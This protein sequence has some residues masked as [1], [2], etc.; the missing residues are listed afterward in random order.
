MRF[1]KYIIVLVFVLNMMILHSLF[2][3]SLHNGHF[4][5]IFYIW[6]PECCVLLDALEQ[7]TRNPA[8]TTVLARSL[9]HILQLSAEKTALSFKT[10]N[11]VPRMLKVACIH[12]QESKRSAIDFTDFSISSTASFQSHEL[13][14]S[15]AESESWEKCMKTFMDLF[16]VYFS[17]SDDAKISIL[18]SSP[19]I[20]CLF[21]LFWE[22]DLRNLM[23][24]YVLD[25]MK[26][27]HSIFHNLLSSLSV[28]G[29]MSFFRLAV[30]STYWRARE[31]KSVSLLQ[32]LG[33]IY[34][35]ER[36]RK[37]FF[38]F[39]DRVAHWNERDVV[40]R[41]SG[42]WNELFFCFVLFLFV[43]LWGFYFYFLYSHINIKI[44]VNWH[45]QLLSSVT[46][47]IKHCSVRVN[48]FCMLYLCWTEILMINN[49]N[50][51]NIT[52]KEI[53]NVFLKMK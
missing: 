25:L 4:Y 35:C 9:L 7:S 17:S 6:Q 42:N 5:L 50:L 49:F 43:C 31:S 39:S 22:E 3:S 21:D 41:S 28:L 38:Q 18:C 33:D 14:Y 44:F 24:M 26:V 36:T 29:L 12:V 52:N 27:C 45:A 19:C 51:K 32:V 53:N 40:N 15:P 23:L 34:T 2:G 30:S 16:A 47:I 20:S 11:A 8:L 1:K 48:V 37:K 46:S 10:L 13:S